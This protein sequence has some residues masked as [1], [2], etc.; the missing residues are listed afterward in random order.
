MW[1]KR[2]IAKCDVC[3]HEWTPFVKTSTHCPKFKSRLWNKSI[4][5]LL[6]APFFL[7]V[8]TGC[9]AASITLSSPL[10]YQVFQR[11]TKTQGTV[12]IK[13]KT[14]FPADSVEASFSGQSIMGML[15][16]TWSKV[17]LDSTGEFHADLSVPAGGFYTLTIRVAHS[18]E[19]SQTSIAHIGV[20]EVFVVAG[21]SNSTNYGEVRQK[22]KTGMVTNVSSQGWQVANDP[23]LGVQDH[24]NQGSF[25]PS[26]GDAM[27]K[28]YGI[29]IGVA[30]VGRG[31]TSVRQWLPKGTPV[32]VMPTYQAYVYNDDSGTLVSDGVLYSNLVDQIKLLGK[33][34]FRAV[35]W[36]QGE[37]DCHQPEGHD[38]SPDTYKSM[39]E[40]LIASARTDAGWNF[41]W[42]LAEATYHAPDD[43]SCPPIQDVQQELWASGIALQGPDTDALTM[44]YREKK[45]QG[46]HFNDAG[47]Q[48]HGRLWSQQVSAYLDNEVR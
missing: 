8:L 36:H 26:F 48:L 20:G 25:I 39:M 12:T 35:L 37:S 19:L 46:I 28:K 23:Q 32:Q 4:L 18:G 7:L 14:L 3:G 16:E 13:G 24:S 31:S 41:P 6:F 10:D 9:G 33:G 42:F 43:Q 34:G 21:Q 15:P 30:S 47:L 1:I 45:G 44:Q 5:Q 29:P 2:R 40:S 17:S 22:T 27:Y 11:Q 38:I